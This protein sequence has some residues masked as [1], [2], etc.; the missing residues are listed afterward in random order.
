V[1]FAPQQATLCNGCF[2]NASNPRDHSCL[3]YLSDYA[4]DD[5]VDD[6]SLREFFNDRTWNTMLKS[7]VLEELFSIYCKSHTTVDQKLFN[8]FK[9]GIINLLKHEVNQ[10]GGELLKKDRIHGYKTCYM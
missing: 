3:G 8:N 5:P 7:Q 6:G 10:I 9:Y 2:E 4:F 1:N